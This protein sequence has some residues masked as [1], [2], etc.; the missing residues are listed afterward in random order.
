MFLGGQ[1]DVARLD[2]AVNDAVAVRRVQ[3]VGNLDTDV[4]DL[5]D[6]QGPTVE[7]IAQRRALDELHDD[8]RMAVHLAD[9]VESYKR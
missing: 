7:P 8:E 6:L 2:V 5:M 3:R 1:E 9:V 4:D